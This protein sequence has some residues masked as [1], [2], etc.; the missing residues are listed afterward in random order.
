MANKE[1]I[2][3]E[4]FKDVCVKLILNL[5]ESCFPD[6][7][8]PDTF[9]TD[10]HLEEL[11]FTDDFYICKINI[12]TDDTYLRGLFNYDVSHQVLTELYP[13][14]INDGVDFEIKRKTMFK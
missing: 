4:N 7:Y 11:S 12:K 9:N 1:S 8:S 13:S 3:M 2:S 10:V 14:V 5:H 6:N